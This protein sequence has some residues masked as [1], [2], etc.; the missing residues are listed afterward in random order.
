MILPSKRLVLVLLA[1]ITPL[2]LLGIGSSPARSAPPSGAPGH[3]TP[4]L[5]DLA[6][7]EGRISDGERTLLLAYALYEDGSLPDAYRGT[8]GWFGTRAVR[9]VRD[10]YIENRATFSPTIARELD[11][12]LAGP[13]NTYCDRPDLPNVDTTTSASFVVNYDMIGGGLTLADYATSLDTTYDTLTAAYGWAT[14]PNCDA[15]TCESGMAPPATW[16]GRYPVQIAPLGATLFGYVTVEQA[17]Y[18]GMVGDNPNTALTETSAFA[19]CMVLNDDFSQFAGNTAQENL[20]GTTSHEFVHAIQ[21]AWGDPGTQQGGMWAESTAAYFEDEVFDAGNTQYQY[22]YADFANSLGAWPDGGNPGGVSEYSNFIFFRYVAEQNGGA[23]SPTGGEAVI[24][25]F[26]ENVGVTDPEVPDLVAWRTTFES[27]GSNNLADFFHQYAIAT[28]FLKDCVSESSYGSIY[29]YEEGQEYRARMAGA[30]PAVQGTIGANPGSYNGSIEDNYAINW[31]S[32]PA[33]GAAAYSVSLAN[34][35]ASGL[36]RA[37]VVCDTGTSLSVIPMPSVV[38]P[39]QNRQVASVDPSG[40]ASVVLVITNQEQTITAAN[41][42]RVVV[43][44]NY[45]ATVGPPVTTM[46]SRIYVP[47]LTR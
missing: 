45:T 24:Q 8:E 35:G 41:P 43:P 7:A 4:Q 2:F 47:A 18:V 6:Y 42:T 3:T 19:S 27:F 21:N 40:C 12:L 9:D 26:F 25:R 14:P 10:A 44:A 46:T 38:G 11:R 33:T 15:T 30:L 32:L 20:D 17:D 16:G 37:S 39:G 13:S 5:I 29:C 23:N 28:K 31:V 36:L 34:T 22:L 1:L